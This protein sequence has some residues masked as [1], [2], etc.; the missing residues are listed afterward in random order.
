MRIFR[1]VLIVF[2]IAFLGE[3][4]S[5]SLH[6]P[7]PG[8]LCGMLILFILLCSGIIKIESIQLISDFLL[9]H[10]AFFF[11]PAGVSLLAYFDV[12]KDSWMWIILTCL[13]TTF[14]TMGVC[15][16]VM[17]ALMHRKEQRHE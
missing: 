15:G 4:L 13:L 9:S 6:L 17:N 7:L 5:K 12:I 11:I 1:E 2:G 14:I 8:S 10:L 3:I 16:W